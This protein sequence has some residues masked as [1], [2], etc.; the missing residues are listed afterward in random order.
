MN[1]IDPS[2]H[3]YGNLWIGRHEIANYLPAA[4]VGH[5]DNIVISNRVERFFNNTIR[6]PAT[7]KEEHGFFEGEGNGPD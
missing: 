4:S 2:Q 7:K 5:W 6:P 1:L 3:Y